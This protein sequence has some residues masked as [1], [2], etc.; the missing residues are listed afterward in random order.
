MR[1]GRRTVR[2]AVLMLVAGLVLVLALPASA[3]SIEPREAEID[4]VLETD[5]SLSVT[6]LLT[7]EFDGAFTGAYR[8]IPLRA[9]ETLSDVEVFEGG[10]A[11][12]P[13]GCTD[14]GCS[15]PPG[16]FGVRDLGGRI[17][18]VWSRLCNRS[19]PCSGSWN[20]AFRRATGCSAPPG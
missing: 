15:S 7:F 20:P 6:E 8:E 1:V 11:Y 16:T 10:T 5:G 9:G 4:L 12:V 17:R 3:R 2:S 14:L 18:I 13:G 19:W